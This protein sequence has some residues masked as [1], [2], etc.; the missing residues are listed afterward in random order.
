MIRKLRTIAIDLCC[1]AVVAGFWALLAFLMISGD[2][3][4]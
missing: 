3:P 2:W 1:A 4:K